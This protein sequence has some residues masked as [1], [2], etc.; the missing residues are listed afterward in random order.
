MISTYYR[1][2]WEKDYRGV[3]IVERTTQATAVPPGWR[4][5]KEQALRDCASRMRTLAMDLMQQA[6][7]AT[8]DKRGI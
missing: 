3:V 8:R 5:T 1:C 2:D 7:A 6:D 4:D